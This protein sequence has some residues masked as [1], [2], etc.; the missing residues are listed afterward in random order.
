MKEDILRFEY[1]NLECKKEASQKFTAGAD[2]FM[3]VTCGN[4]RQSLHAKNLACIRRQFYLWKCLPT[5]I[6]GNF[7]CADLS[8]VYSN[9]YSVYSVLNND[10]LFSHHHLVDQL[11]T[12]MLAFLGIGFLI[13]LDFRG[14]NFLPNKRWS[15]HTTKIFKV[16]EL[17]LSKFR[18]ISK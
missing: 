9:L 1:S 4:R 8:S 2:K 5:A 12:Q 11:S 3:P 14:V 7:A 17:R 13:S 15:E 10:T 16:C 6:A 18:T